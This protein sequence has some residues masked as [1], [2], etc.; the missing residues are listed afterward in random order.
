MK[1]YD[2]YRLYDKPNILSCLKV[3]I[4]EWFGHACSADNDFIKNV[5]TETIHKKSV[6]HN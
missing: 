5:L 3:M 1:M 4:T 2:L 6:I